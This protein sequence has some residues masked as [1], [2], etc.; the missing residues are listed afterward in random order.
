M[1]YGGLRDS[2]ARILHNTRRAVADLALQL[3]ALKEREG[4]EGEGEGGAAAGEEWE[5]DDDDDDDDHDEEK[6]Q[7]K[8][9][10]K[11]KEKEGKST[12]ELEKEN[13][14]QPPPPPPPHPQH[15]ER[16]CY[17]VPLNS[18][19]FGVPWRQT[20]AVLRA[21]R[22]DMVVL[23][24]DAGKFVELDMDKQVGVEDGWVGG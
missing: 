1:G 2:P 23:G 21:G 7:G 6:E 13:P 18:G 24:I 10:E 17:A 19:R 22:L 20:R 4:V 8:E 16:K 3:L 15:L 5:E 12:N 9:Q 14:N 11:E